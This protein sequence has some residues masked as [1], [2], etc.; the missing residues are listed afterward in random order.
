MEKL[1]SVA[2]T[3][4]PSPRMPVLF[5]GHGNP[6]NAI[7]DNDI[8]RMWQKI[9]SN[10]PQAQ[11]IV[12]MSAHWQTRGTHVTDAPTQEII[13]DFYGFPQELY[14]VE[15]KAQ[16]SPTLAAE[17]Q[18]AFLAYE[19]KLDSSWGLDHGTWSVMKHLAPEPQIPVL[20]ISIDATKSLEDLLQ[21]FKDL[22]PL[23]DNGVIFI[24]SG[25]IVHN[26]GMLNFQDSTIFD[27][28]EDFDLKS[29]DAISMKNHQLLTHP[30]K[31]SKTAHLAIP[32]DDHYR[33]MLAVMALLDNNEEIHY[34]NEMIDL[35]SVGMRSF[36]SA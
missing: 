17:L 13:Y 9:G 22:R 28:A 15:Y 30:D 31:I 26:L 16:G 33:P 36:I 32:T 29:A 35:G 1:K 34:F 5:V 21:Q 12:V 27:W 19:A 4:K 20:Q 18:K 7:S 14:E 23:R 10:L 3:L 25:N 24:G 2:R 8:T 11:A 6:M